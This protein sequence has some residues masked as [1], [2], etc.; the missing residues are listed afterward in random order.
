MDIKDRVFTALNALGKTPDDICTFLMR[1]G[2]TGQRKSICKC[3]IAKYLREET[4][5]VVS[6]SSESILADD[7]AE[8]IK[9]TMPKNVGEFIVRFDRGEFGALNNDCI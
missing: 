1:R 8:T 2:I 4:G 6:V 5:I 3:P 7:I 9:M